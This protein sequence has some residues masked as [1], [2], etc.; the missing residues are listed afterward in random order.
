MNRRSFCAIS[1]FN[2]NFRMMDFARF[3]LI[4]WC[5]G[6]GCIVSFAD[7]YTNHAFR[8]D[9]LAYNPFPQLV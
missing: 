4:S 9:E 6:T 8:R 2:P 7:W 1:Y 5:L 3:S